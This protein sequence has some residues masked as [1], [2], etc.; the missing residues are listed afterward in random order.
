MIVIII[1]L[2][3]KIIIIN[4]VDTD[5]NPIT[6][7]VVKYAAI[8]S[9]GTLQFQPFK[10]CMHNYVQKYIHLTAYLLLYLYMCS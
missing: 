9:H 1:A 4:Y 3:F 8:L 7:F 2:H 10:V 6:K 5:H